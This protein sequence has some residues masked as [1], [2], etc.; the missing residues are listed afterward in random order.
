MRPRGREMYCLLLTAAAACMQDSD[1]AVVQGARSTT[2]DRARVVKAR[3]GE[4]IC[5]NCF[6]AKC[7]VSG[8][9]RTGLQLAWV[10][11]CLWTGRGWWLIARFR[12]D[13]LL[14][15][16]TA[17]IVFTHTRPLIT[18]DGW[19][20]PTIVVDNSRITPLSYSHSR[21]SFKISCI[22]KNFDL[23]ALWLNKPWTS[24]AYVQC[25]NN[26]YNFTTY[27]VK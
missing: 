4:A 26:H 21:F 14:P 23:L 5:G 12:Y 11:A 15:P 27:T 25:H 3:R 19:T 10:R 6:I 8:Q 7:A 24:L 1:A 17:N 20:W 22:L 2:L 18:T 16:A 13:V 9:I